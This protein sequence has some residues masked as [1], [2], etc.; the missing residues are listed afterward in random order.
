MITPLGLGTLGGAGPRDRGPAQEDARKEAVEDLLQRAPRET[1]LLPDL[2]GCVDP[3]RE[4]SA[5]GPIVHPLGEPAQPAELVADVG[6]VVERADAPIV[7]D[8]HEQLMR[9]PSLVAAPLP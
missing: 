6:H 8:T 7:L 2:V 3:L 5:G 9:S 4:A 1:L